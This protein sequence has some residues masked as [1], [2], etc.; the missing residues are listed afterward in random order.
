MPA[1]VKVA[2]VSEIPP[3][4]VKEVEVAG[5]K[6]ALANVDGAFYAIDN[7]C[8]HRG[9]PL[10]EGYLEG[11]LLECPWHGWQWNVETGECSFN[12]AVKVPIYEIKIEGEDILIGHG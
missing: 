5:K 6:I 4:K 7:V 3:G 2:Q 10:A 12:P 11:E 1:F 9:G 8:L